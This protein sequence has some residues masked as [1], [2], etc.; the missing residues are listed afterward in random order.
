MYYKNSITSIIV[1]KWHQR[2]SDQSGQIAVI[3]LLLMVV[4]MTV[5]LSLASRTTQEL[6]ISSQ[7]SDSTRVFNAAESGVEEA[8]S[9]DIESGAVGGTLN[10]PNSTVDYSVISAKNF[11]TQIKEGQSLLVNINK[12]ITGTPSVTIN[13]WKD[14]DTD[15][16]TDDP[17]SLIIAKYYQTSPGAALRVSY[18]PVGICEELGERN[19]GFDAATPVGGNYK[20]ETAFTL[21]NTVKFLRIKAVYNNTDIKVSNV[22][23]SAPNQFHTVR[24]TATNDLGDETRIIEV[25]R[26]LSTAPSFMDYALYTPGNLTH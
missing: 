13:W 10:L 8:L 14:K 22:P 25:Q 23:S 7:Q 16:T 11:E 2:Q 24:S 9:Q 4:L 6:F 20:I 15:C 18:H 19:D 21:D 3:V 5:G 1:Q 26:T 17:A 12:Q